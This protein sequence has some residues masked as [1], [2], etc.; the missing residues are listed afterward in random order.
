MDNNIN[1]S[2]TRPIAQWLGSGVALIGSLTSDEPHR[3]H[4]GGIPPATGLISSSGRAH[5]IHLLYEQV[6]AECILKRV[7]PRTALGD[8]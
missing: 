1:R 6:H 2:T 3:R 4:E 8:T 7:S 5:D